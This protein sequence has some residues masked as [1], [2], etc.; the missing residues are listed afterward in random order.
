MRKPTSSPRWQGIFRALGFGRRAEHKGIQQVK[1]HAFRLEPLED[2]H[3][4]SVL[5]WDPQQSG[6]SNLGGSGTWTGGGRGVSP[7]FFGKSR[8]GAGQPRQKKACP[9]WRRLTVALR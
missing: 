8:S 9:R 7:R 4:L 6:G 3:L 5:C 1:R 2:R